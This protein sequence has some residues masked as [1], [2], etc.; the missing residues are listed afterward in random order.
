MNLKKVYI[1]FP[2]V[3]LSVEWIIVL[4]LHYHNP[5]NFMTMSIDTLY[6][7]LIGLA[8]I[9]LGYYTFGSFYV[10]EPDKLP[11]DSYKVDI[12]E[13]LLGKI[14]LLLSFLAFLG[15][16]IIAIEV[17]KIT[18]NF[19]LYFDNPI[20]VRGLIV[21]MQEGEI[22]S[23]SYTRYKL[24]VYLFSLVKPLATIGGFMSILKSRW[25]FVGLIPLLLMLINSVINLNRFG[26]IS[27]LGFWFFGRIYS[28]MYLE[29]EERKKVL[30][31]TG[32]YILI[33]LAFIII[34]FSFILNIREAYKSNISYFLM[35]SVYLYFTGSGSA[36]DKISFWGMKPLYGASSFRSIVKWL[37]MAGLIDSEH[38][39]SYYNNFVNIGQGRV[40]ILNTYTFAKSP[41]EDFGILG[42]G[43]I[44][45]FWGITT[46][47]SIERCFKKFTLYNVYFV[48]LMLLS[49]VMTFYEFF[50][51]GIVVYIFWFFVIYLIQ[52]Y[53]DNRK[54]TSKIYPSS[55]KK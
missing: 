32:I 26:L 21:Q 35:R 48:A 9:V 7:I 29:A 51:H 15:L 39:L 28:V 3:I 50:F 52:K 16:M 24:G 20:V 30:K 25:K 41:Y 10:S 40:I 22:A 2:M 45:M 18:N 19:K 53:L 55:I 38:I 1:H 43:I 12:N 31:K 49:L 27:A 4:Y 42:V 33:T 46:R 34:F 23:V 17:A 44:S 36:F 54:G 8:F 5:Y 6:I 37:S 47:Y 11:G 14:L 13:A